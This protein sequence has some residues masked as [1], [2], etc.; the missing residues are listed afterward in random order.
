MG[1][2]ATFRDGGGFRICPTDLSPNRSPFPPTIGRL[3]AADPLY[4]FSIRVLPPI[5]SAGIILCF[6]RLAEVGGSNFG[7]PPPFTSANYLRQI[8]PLF[9]T[10][11]GSRRK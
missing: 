3:E 5:T 4:T 11:G 2:T 6:Q 8:Y 10:L 7:L 1:A 9:S